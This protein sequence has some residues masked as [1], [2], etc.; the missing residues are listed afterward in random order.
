MAV[1]K[2]IEKFVN[3]LITKGGNLLVFTR[4]AAW[5]KIDRISGAPGKSQ[6]V[7][8]TTFWNLN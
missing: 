8:K 3:E 4:I 6:R 5:F 1:C 7:L 2:S